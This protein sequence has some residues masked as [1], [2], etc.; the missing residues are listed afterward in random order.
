MLMALIAAILWGISGTCGQFLF[1]QRGVGV[2][3]LMSVRMLGAGTLLLITALLRKDDHVWTIWHN[4]EDRRKILVFGILGMLAV[5]YT[6]FAAIKHSNAAT[7]TILQFSAPVLIAV[8]LAARYHQKLNRLGYAAIL[9]AILGTFILVTHGNIHKLNM[10]PM[11]FALGIASAVSLAFYTL[12]P[13]TLLKKYSSLSVVGWGVI[14][15]RCYDLTCQSALECRWQLGRLCL[16]QLPLYSDIRNPDTI[17]F[18]YPGS[19]VHRWSEGKPVNLS[20]AS[21]S[22]FG[23]SIMVGCFISVDGLAGC[24]T[25]YYNCI[26]AVCR[27][28]V[29]GRLKSTVRYL[30]ALALLQ[31]SFIKRKLLGG[32]YLYPAK[33]RT[34]RIEQIIVFFRNNG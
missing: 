1:Q 10:S 21:F 29:T 22:H 15:W 24:N 3:W 30:I 11:A 27:E 31:Q 18:I 26:F 9:L 16:C 32:M 34:L 12:M 17:L 4:K 13:G 23:S 25:H 7:A 19:A 28:T 8:Y 2:E 6:Y 14:Y 33:I 20:R 5:Q